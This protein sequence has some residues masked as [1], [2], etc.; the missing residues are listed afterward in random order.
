MTFKDKLCDDTLKHYYFSL[1]DGEYESYTH[2]YEDMVLVKKNCYAYN[3]VDHIA[4][5]VLRI[6]SWVMLFLL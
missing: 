1:Q 2:F 3:P 6:L 5:K 4:R